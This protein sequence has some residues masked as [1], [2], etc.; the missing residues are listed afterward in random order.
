M[1]NK[2]PLINYFKK[3]LEASLW[4]RSFARYDHR[5]LLGYG[6][7][8]QDI[9]DSKAEA[10]T[11]Y[12]MEKVKENPKGSIKYNHLQLKALGWTDYEIVQAQ[13]NASSKN[14]TRNKIIVGIAVVAIV[15]YLLVSTGTIKNL[16]LN[17]KN[18]T[19]NVNSKGIPPEVMAFINS[20][21]TEG[22]PYVVVEG[23]LN[24]LIKNKTEDGSAIHHLN[25]SNVSSSGDG[26][27]NPPAASTELRYVQEKTKSTCE[28]NFVADRV[29]ID[30]NTDALGKFFKETF[31]FVAGVI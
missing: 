27:E 6:W 9:A 2:E 8:E 28:F 13:E 14:S 4:N 21:G 31:K 25:T 24:P 17:S 3:F 7:T 19:I 10:L 1:N 30:C 11:R 18:E 15:L 20:N 12:F 22:V 16:Q 23:E 26:G 29:I 5:G